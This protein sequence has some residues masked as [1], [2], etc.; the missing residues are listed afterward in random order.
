ML[1]TLALV[2]LVSSIVP[3]YPKFFELVGQFKLYASPILEGWS[4][5]DSTPC[6]TLLYLSHLHKEKKDTQLFPGFDKKVLSEVYDVVWQEYA[7]ACQESG[8]RFTPC[9]KGLTTILLKQA[10]TK[11][12]MSA[13][14]SKAL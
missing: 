10:E 4:G 12:L 2:S 8:F 13:K 6:V 3:D 5:I 1:S 14:K 9:I 7:K 11:K